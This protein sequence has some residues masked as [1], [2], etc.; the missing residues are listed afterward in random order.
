MNNQF[1]HFN[2]IWF[3]DFEFKVTPGEKQVPV[4]MVAQEYRSGK[5][6]KIW[7]ENESDVVTQSLPIDLSDS[8]LFVSYYASAELGCFLSLGWKMPERILDL[9]AEFVNLT[10][11]KKN[12]FGKGLLGASKYFGLPAM[13]HLEKDRIRDIILTKS[14]FSECEKQEILDYC[15][16]DVIALSELFKAMIELVDLPRAL[17]RGRYMAAVAFMEFS[18]VPIDHDS[19]EKIKL[20]WD[21]IKL[22]LIHEVDKDFKCYFG[23]TFKTDRFVKWLATKQ[24]EWPL[25]ESG[26]LKLDDDTF[27]EMSIAHPEIESLRQLRK[28]IS[29]LRLSELPVGSDGR[30]RVLLSPFGSKTGRNQPSNSRFIFGPA[31]WMR[32]LIRPK[33]GYS[34][35]YIDY[36]QQELAIAAAFSGDS[37][38]IQAYESG[39]FYLSFAKLAGAAPK[40]ATKESHGDVRDKYKTVSLGVLYGLTAEG[41]ARKLR[42]PMCL[43]KH[44]L[45]KHQEIFRRFW[46][47]STEVQDCA[48]LTKQVSTVFGWNY[49]LDDESEINTRTLRNFPMQGNGAEILRLAC[50]MGVESGIKI[51]CPVHD[52]VLIEAPSDEI[53]QRTEEMRSIMAEASRIVLANLSLKTDYK[54]VHFPDRYMD[55]RGKGMWEK[56]S[57]L[58]G[59]EVYV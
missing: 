10:S 27:K 35:S 52:A 44:L 9:Y 13:D 59:L 24:I 42:I 53:N 58:I 20:K 54:I 7:F 11:G 6:I 50:C 16:S 36:S 15:A 57:S 26:H 38:M 18:G 8:S 4:C 37:N 34:I 28:T 46:E 47:W 56:V 29:L 31:A 40:D 19:L 49:W 1:S 2:K 55:P 25:L 30:N 3:V 21:N 39:D 22:E 14:C 45:Q 43:G 33:P 41:I 5:M 23:T 51:C 17:L 32:S 48:L 12:F